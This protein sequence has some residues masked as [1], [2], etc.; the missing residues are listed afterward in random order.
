MKQWPGVEMVGELR[1]TLERILD[2]AREGRDNDEPAS[3]DIEDWA[4]SAVGKQLGEIATEIDRLYLWIDDLQSRMY[5]N[6]VYCGHR[7]G[8]ADSVPPSMQEALYRHIAECSKHPLS[9]T[10][11]A[12]EAATHALRSYEHG[13]AAPGL[14]HSVAEHCESLLKATGGQ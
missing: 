3:N 2:R 5:I 13:N 1:D 9:A 12:L 7:Y 8:P 6:C 4:D 10:L 11:R 14:A